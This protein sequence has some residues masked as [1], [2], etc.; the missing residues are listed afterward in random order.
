MPPSLTRVHSN[1]TGTGTDTS[2]TTP[3]A[4]PS[5]LNKDCE[6][7]IKLGDPKSISTYRGKQPSEIK[8]IFNLQA[9]K[10]ARDR[11]KALLM[12]HAI[13]AQQL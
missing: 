6:V 3:G 1:G 8:K 12:V 9:Q 13:T 11:A 10:A 5:D 4:S 2:N 7:I